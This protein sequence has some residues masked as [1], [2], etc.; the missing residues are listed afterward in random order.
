[1]NRIFIYYNSHLNY[2][3]TSEGVQNRPPQDVSL[4]HAD[5]FELKA[6]KTSQAH[7]KLLP[8]AGSP[9]CV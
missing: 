5:Y 9:A 8:L 6:L 4:W 7:K 3:I 1:M 2:I